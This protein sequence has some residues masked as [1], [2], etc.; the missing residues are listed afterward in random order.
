MPQRSITYCRETAVSKNDELFRIPARANK[1]GHK[2]SLSRSRRES[3]GEEPSAE[4]GQRDWDGLF[5]IVS[6]PRPWVAISSRRS[7]SS[8][9]VAVRSGSTDFRAQ[10]VVH[11]ATRHARFRFIGTAQSVGGPISKHGCFLQQTTRRSSYFQ[12]IP[13]SKPTGTRC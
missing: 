3:V 10:Q 9:G 13:D 8:M 6:Y 12:H 2:G 1:Y 4:C 11:K 5:C 7:W